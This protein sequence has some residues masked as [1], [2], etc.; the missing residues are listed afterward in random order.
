MIRL[1]KTTDIFNRILELTKFVKKREKY[2][3]S[4]FYGVMCCEIE[5]HKYLCATNMNVAMCYKI[6]DDRCNLFTIGYHYEIIAK[7]AKEI[8]LNGKQEK[9]P[10]FEALCNQDYVK[11]FTKRQ[12]GNTH[13]ISELCCEIAQK[14]YFVNISNF[15]ILPRIFSKVDVSFQKND[16]TQQKGV[17]LDIDDDDVICLIMPLRKGY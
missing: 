8:V 4:L 16:E 1:D 6:P 11:N 14:D 12:S 7:N 10:D 17:R 3:D 5:G 15:L 2:E 13:F 9:I